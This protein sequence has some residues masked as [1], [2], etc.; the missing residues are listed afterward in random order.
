MSASNRGTAARNMGVHRA[1]TPL[2]AFSDDDSWWAADALERATGHFARYPSLGLLAARVLVGGSG[3]LDP[4]CVLM[5]RGTRRPGAPGPSVFGFLACGAI[6]RRD[7]FL[8]AGGFDERY[9]IGGEETLLAIDLAAAGWTVAY[10]DDVV[11]HHHPARGTRPGRDRTMVRNDLWT[12]WLRRPAPVAARTTLA[13]L[14]PGRFGG[15]VDAAAGAR[16]VR[17]ERRPLPRS[18]ERD[19]RALGG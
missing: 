10:A 15:L 16:W 4:T 5:Q 3:R 17:R 12:S 11:A 1:R 8:Q 2:V 14:R 19:L 9:G 13:A 18:V 7:A 6:V